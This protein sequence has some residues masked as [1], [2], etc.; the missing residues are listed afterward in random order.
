MRKGQGDDLVATPYEEN[1]VVTVQSDW[2]RQMA[3]R[4]EHIIY[5]ERRCTSSM[6]MQ[7]LYE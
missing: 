6:L 2:N 7:L 1:V 5:F 4:L 3:S